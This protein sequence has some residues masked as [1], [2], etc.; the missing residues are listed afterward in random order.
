M[1]I[2]LEKPYSFFR[3]KFKGHHLCEESLDPSAHE[4]PSEKQMAHSNEWLKDVTQWNCYRAVARS[5]GA[6][7]G[8]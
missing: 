4:G 2:Y 1:H 6:R 8:W 3:T 7:R 5:R